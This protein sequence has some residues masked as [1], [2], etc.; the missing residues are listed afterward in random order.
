MIDQNQ[1]HPFAEVTRLLRSKRQKLYVKQGYLAL[2]RNVIVMAFLVM[3]AF[4]WVF[5]VTAV[6]GSDMYPAILDGDLLLGYRLETNYQKNDV[7]VCTIEGKEVVGRI[8]AKAGDRVDIT[9]DGRLF[10]NGTEQ[11]GEI[12]FPTYAGEQSY[13]Y[14][15]P[16]SCIYILGDYRTHATDSRDFG[17]VELQDVISKV[18]SVF[19]NRGI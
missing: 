1:L 5:S 9:E 16:D 6:R 19:R 4:T 11:Q 13:P 7:V 18:V 3:I 10:V 17:A 2:L 15:V 14:V 8:V 12:V